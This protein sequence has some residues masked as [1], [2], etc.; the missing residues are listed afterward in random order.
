M[1]V[2]GYLVQLDTEAHEVNSAESGPRA[3]ATITI[4][5]ISRKSLRDGA[6]CALANLE[7]Y[8]SIVDA[9]LG[10]LRARRNIFLFL[11]RAKI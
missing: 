1:K 5:A 11:K 3:L 4:H 2:H 9:D 10:G 7:T 6:A 8:A